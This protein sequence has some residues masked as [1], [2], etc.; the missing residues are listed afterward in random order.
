MR[1]QASERQ[2]Q[3]DADKLVAECLN[4]AYERRHE[5]EKVARVQFL[6]FSGGGGPFQ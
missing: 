2:N 4:S 3:R 6:G 5:S 1:D